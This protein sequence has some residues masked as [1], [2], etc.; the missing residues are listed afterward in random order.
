MA[1]KQSEPTYSYSRY[2]FVGAV[3]G[4]YFGLFYN[5][6]D[7]ELNLVTPIL[8]AVVVGVVMTV[9]FAFQKR[10]SLTALP[11]YFVTTFIKASLILIVLEGRLLLYDMGGKV[12]VT[13]F[14]VLMALL[15]SLWFAY[16]QKRLGLASG[17]GKA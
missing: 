8:L 17:K 14:T 10:P 11:L 13:A 1:K 7:R 5:P 15:T 6:P 2:L 4:L 9:L 12:A 3:L 16:D